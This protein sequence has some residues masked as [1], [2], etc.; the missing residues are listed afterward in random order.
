MLTQQAVYEALLRGKREA[1]HERVG[2]AVETVH[3]DQLEAFSEVLAYHY[4]R[5]AER[6][7]GGGVSGPGEPEGVAG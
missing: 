3:G 6:R 1:L 4:G 5:S 2:R 7:Q